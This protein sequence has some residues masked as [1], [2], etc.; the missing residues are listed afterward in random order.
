MH[1]FD[2][3]DPS[4]LE[5][6]DAQLWVLAIAMLLIFAAGIA[7]LI[8]PAAFSGPVILTAGVLK[9]V[10]V[11][12]CVLS[13]LVVGYLM[14]RRV[15]IGRLRRRL[16]EEESRRQRLLNEASADLLA[17]LPSTEHFRDRLAMEFRRAANAQLPLS[18]VMV[19]IRPAGRL[20]D[21][22]DITMAYGDAAKA[23]IRKLRGEDSIYLFRQGVFGVVL[24]GVVAAN[25]RLV[26]E[27]LS[28][29]LASAS[30]DVPRFTSHLESVSFPEDVATA[31]QME[32][33]AKLFSPEDFAERAAA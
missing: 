12:F 3:I 20:T 33:A 31:H 10:F 14:E 27:R 16:K 23:M 29:G 25:A 7:L 6:R 4:K 32:K 19:S 2:H 18:L 13:M 15:E 5:R 9:R 21:A 28:A 30:G 22:G 8:Y 26:Q 1:I 24:P 17:G 11:G